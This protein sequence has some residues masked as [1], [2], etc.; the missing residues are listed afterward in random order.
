MKFKVKDLEV[1]KLSFQKNVLGSGEII[2]IKYNNETLELQ[3]PKIII[4]SLIKENDHEYLVLRI[5]PTQACKTFC[6]KLMEIE[7]FFNSK[8][9]NPIK[10]IFNDHTFTVKIP[11]KY[12]KPLVTIYK[13][14]RLFNYY[15]LTKN[16]EVMCLL[17]LDKIWINQYKEP[18][19]NLT[20]KELMIIA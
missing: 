19:Y 13:E 17:T 11:F 16:T 4:D 7:E 10:T 3:T 15:N 2:N 14:D 18:N 1:S 20:V 6:S 9:E 5:L 12:S 8:L